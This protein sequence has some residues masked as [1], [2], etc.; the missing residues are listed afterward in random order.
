[1]T[2]G[3]TVLKAVESPGYES[4]INLESAHAEKSITVTWDVTVVG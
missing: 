4:L 2:S 1:M 3:V